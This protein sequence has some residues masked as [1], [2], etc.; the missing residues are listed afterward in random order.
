MHCVLWRP[1]ARGRAAEELV[2]FRLSTNDGCCEGE[3]GTGVSLVQKEAPRVL[4]I[5]SRYLGL[6]WLFKIPLV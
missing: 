3:G 4:F 5:S 1:I 6:S 2:G